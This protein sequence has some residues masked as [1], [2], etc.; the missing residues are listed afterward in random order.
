MNEK[1]NN[2]QEY[3]APELV[4][5]GDA[6]RLTLGCTGTSKD[7]CTCAECNDQALEVY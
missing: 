2:T 3:I 7:N 6:D 4:E 5:L 1:I